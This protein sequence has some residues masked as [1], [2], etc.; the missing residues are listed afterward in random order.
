MP[1]AQARLCLLFDQQASDGLLRQLTYLKRAS[2]LTASYIPRVP[3]P[4]YK[5]SPHHVSLCVSP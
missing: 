4:P 3:I 2:S 5:A 1:L